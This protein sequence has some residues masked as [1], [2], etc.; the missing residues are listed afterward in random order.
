M[1]LEWDIDA[2]SIF[3]IEYKELIASRV[4]KQGKIPILDANVA[5]KSLFLFIMGQNKR[6]W[7]V[8]VK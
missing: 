8:L 3:S 7:K 1:I 4:S 2:N 6:L 5:A